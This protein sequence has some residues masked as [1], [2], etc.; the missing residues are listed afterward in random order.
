[1]LGGRGRHGPLT[2]MMEETLQRGRRAIERHGELL[3]QHGHRRVDRFDAA[4]DVGHQVTTLEA[5][6]VPAMRH[7]VV[8][9][10]VDVVENGGRQ[11]P[12]GQPAEIM[13]VVA[14]AKAHDPTKLDCRR[15]EVNSIAA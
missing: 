4:Q 14:V 5:R 2:L 1:M 6:R 9:C 15:I 8:G 13:K 11:A 7:L 12:L 3:A 10:S